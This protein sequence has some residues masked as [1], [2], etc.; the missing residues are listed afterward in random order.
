MT[1]VWRLTCCAIWVQW[2]L[3][4][5]IALELAKRETL[6]KILHAFSYI[7]VED[8]R[9]EMDMLLFSLIYSSC[10][11]P[12]DAMTPILALWQTKKKKKV[13]I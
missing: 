2:A 5:N 3:W 6:I 10:R 1:I 7:F 9:R 11:E 12:F 13:F 4:E 8:D